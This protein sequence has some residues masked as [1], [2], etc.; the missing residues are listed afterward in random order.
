MEKAL[1]RVLEARGPTACA[2][3]RCA[4]RVRQ[5]YKCPHIRSEHLW[6]AAAELAETRGSA[7][8]FVRQKLRDPSY[9]GHSTFAAIGGDLVT[10]LCE[11]ALD[12]AATPLTAVEVM[13]AIETFECGTVARILDEFL[14]SQ[15]VLYSF[16]ED[17]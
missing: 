5:T 6:L 4:D 11:T 3:V 17:A 7:A 13:R 15:P 12:R 2:I 9:A 10:P 1:H 8:S 14:Y 16:E